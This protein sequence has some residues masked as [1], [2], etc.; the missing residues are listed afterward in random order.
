MELVDYRHRYVGVHLAS[1]HL[2]AVGRHSSE[3]TFETTT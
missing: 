1:F 2:G 3:A